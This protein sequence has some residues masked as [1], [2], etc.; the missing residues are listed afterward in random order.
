MLTESERFEPYVTYICTDTQPAASVQWKD[1]LNSLCNKGPLSSDSTMIPSCL[2]SWEPCWISAFQS[3]H[4]NRMRVCLCLSGPLWKPH[5]PRTDCCYFLH[6]AIIYMGSN[7]LENV[8]LGNAHLLRVIVCGLSGVRWNKICSALRATGPGSQTAHR[9][10]H[11]ECEPLNQPPPPSLPSQ[12]PWPLTLE[13]LT[14]SF[15]QTIP[16]YTHRHIYW[17]F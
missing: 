7:G 12:P 14:L 5:G 9:M 4:R 17:S 8:Q 10:G 13:A 16:L 1:S 3:A 11:P 2:W 6:P 15:C